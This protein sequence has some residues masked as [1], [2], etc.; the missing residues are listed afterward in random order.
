MTVLVLTVTLTVG[1]L[2]VAVAVAVAV[3]LGLAAR[4]RCSSPCPSSCPRCV[5]G[6]VERVA[7]RVGARVAGWPHCVPAPAPSVA[8]DGRGDRL[9]ARLTRQGDDLGR[10]LPSRPST[11]STELL[12]LR[13]APAPVSVKV[14]VDARDGLAVD[15]HD[16]GRER[17]G[18][19]GRRR[20]RLRR[21]ADVA[22]VGRSVAE[23][24]RSVSR[25]GRA[26][27]RRRDGQDLTHDRGGV[28]DGE[29]GTAVVGVGG[30]PHR[31]RPRHR[32]RRWQPR[33]ASRSRRRFHR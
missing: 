6:A 21:Q 10:G 19:V 14:T 33:A 12:P 22:S 1:Q 25:R 4:R 31:R 20:G 18:R 9:R 11:P 15:V 16:R 8:L 23:G 24:E 5:G 30:Q 29:G 26:T 7:L 27:H 2:G 32:H 28:V 17:P 3:G 13:N